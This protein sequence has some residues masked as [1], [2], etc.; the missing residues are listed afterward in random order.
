MSPSPVSPT[1]FTNIVSFAAL[2]T[3]SEVGSIDDLVKTIFRD[4]TISTIRAPPAHLTLIPSIS[5]LW[6]INPLAPHPLDA[7]FAILK[8]L[9]DTGAD[10]TIMRLDVANSLNLSI[11]PTAQLP[12]SVRLKAAGGD[13]MDMVGILEDGFD[14]T[15]P[16]NNG[17]LQ[18]FRASQ[19]VVRRCIHPCILGVPFLAEADISIR[20]KHRTITQ[21]LT[22]ATFNISIC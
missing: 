19:V 9:L 14:F 18:T 6:S 15:A 21:H 16:D 10:L 17:F 22:N 2:T 13:N 5:L 8:G 3:L 7:I 4:P 20:A 1:L 11:V 12:I